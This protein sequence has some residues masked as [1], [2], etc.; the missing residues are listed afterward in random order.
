MDFQQELHASDTPNQNKRSKNMAI[1]SMI[2]GIV[3][4]VTCCCIYSAMICGALGII[5]ALLSR[6]GNDAL[7]AQETAGLILSSIGLVLSVAIYIGIFVVTLRQ[8][9]GIDGFLQE[10][11]RLYDAATMEELYQSLGTF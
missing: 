3:A 9:G 1:A 6:G 4:L 2:L 7:E 10:Y 5:L 11:M 8:Y